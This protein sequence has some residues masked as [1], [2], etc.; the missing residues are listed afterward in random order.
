MGD[1]LYLAWRYL[2]YHKIKTAILVT[3]L[4]LI[5]Y[6]PLGLDI[7]V[8]H[9][10]EQLRARAAATPLIVGAKGSPLELVLN[11]LYFESD[12]P[13]TTSIA[14]ASRI[15]QTGLGAAI[16]IYTGFK[17]SGFPIVGTT[18]DYF[19]FRSLDVDQGR[20]LSMLG[21]CVVGCEV[22][23]QLEL[24]P[25]DTLTSSARNP[26]DLTGGYPLRM[27][28]VGIFAATGTADDRAVFVDIKTAWVIAGLGHGHTDVTA[29]HTE[30]SVAADAA[31]RRY[32]QITA[33]NQNFFHFHGDLTEFP[34]TAIVVL[35]DNEKSSTLLRGRYLNAD[36]PVQIVRPVDVM[37][38]LLATILKVRAFM[39]AS[40]ALV[41][42]ATLLTTGLVLMLSLRLRKG[43]LATM[44]RLGC[45]RFKIVSIVACENLAIVILAASFT[46]LL[47][48]V[49]LRFGAE[50]IRWFLL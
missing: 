35:T 19:S 29:D 41:G 21:E 24:A 17:A 12:H 13:E 18:V 39:V 31:V 7:L 10:A 2:R 5:A 38:Q 50:A 20:Q 23:R 33:E 16:P 46:I 30:S 34:A 28:V 48:L 43:E 15:D 40:A 6:L 36:R 26:F 4:T 42:L 22:A 1:S 32:Q 49:T 25:N 9:S 37:D 11:T 45:A 47:T 14:E 44:A 27:T 3:S 8:N